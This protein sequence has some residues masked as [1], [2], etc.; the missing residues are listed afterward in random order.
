MA[1]LPHW[2]ANFE[3]FSVRDSLASVKSGLHNELRKRDDNACNWIV[4]EASFLEWK[5]RSRVSTLSLADLPDMHGDAGA[6]RFLALLGDMGSGKTVTTAYVVDHLSKD[7]VVCKYYCAD[8]RGCADDHDTID[9]VNIL[10]SLLYQLLQQ[11]P[12]LKF[13]FWDWFKKTQETGIPVKPTD[14]EK[15]LRDF[16]CDLVTTSQDR[17][18]VVL[19]GLDECER[20]LQGELFSFLA[21]SINPETCCSVLISS[22]YDERI[23]DALPPGALKVHLQHSLARARTI[24]SY[25]CEKHRISNPVA[26][27]QAVTDELSERANGSAIWLRIALEFLSKLRIKDTGRLQQALEKLPTHH[28][29]GELYQRLF[30]KACEDIPQAPELLREVLE[31]LATGGRSMLVDEIACAI[32]IDVEDLTTSTGLRADHMT[33]ANLRRERVGSTCLI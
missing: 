12:G 5:E 9:L 25:L 29:L 32:S 13:R 23:E 11:K 31:T 28:R 8:N 3:L 30:K 15:E 6:S 10:Q 16:V 21:N 27:R 22:R 2:R 4:S 33:V 17:I 18:F 26:I 24:V 1:R 19:D 20:V 14:S 7:N